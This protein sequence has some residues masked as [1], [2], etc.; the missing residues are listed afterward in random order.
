MDKE[1]RQ[2]KLLGLIR[3]K[4]V[5]TQG[6]L[7]SHLER[8]GFTATQSSISRDLEELGVVKR[9]GR[10]VVPGV[11]N[12][13]AAAR[14]LVS[15]EV[16]G[17]ALV[18]ARCEP[19]LASAVAVEIDGAAIKE[20]VGTLAGEDTIFIAVAERKAQRVVI[21]KIWELFG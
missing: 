20:I 6:E 7:A 19:G 4:P 13:A 3:A 15:L 1:K 5:S 14:G 12:G 18:V 17:D 16:A 8:A 9:R 10:Y 11:G 21:K 2:Q